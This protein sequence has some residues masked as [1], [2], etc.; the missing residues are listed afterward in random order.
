[1]E[2]S[3]LKNKLMS[4]LA[5]AKAQNLVDL[6]VIPYLDLINS[7]PFFATSSSCYGRLVIMDLPSKK[8]NE[9][10][11]LRKWH[12]KISLDEFLD[13]LYNTHGKRIWFKVD[14]LI[15]H[16]SVD[17]V[18]H[19]SRLLDVKTRAGIKRGGIF[20]IRPNRVQIEVEGTQ[21]MEVPIKFDNRVL[22]TDDYAE[23][24]VNEANRKMEENIKQ[25]ERFEKEFRNEFREELSQF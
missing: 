2:W 11:F 1:M 13:G 19:A 6:E 3:Q 21:K 7:L 17:N 18:E 15:L 24:L 20:S 14:P 5:E 4:G 25:W 23:I 22:I 12:R 10:Q 8:K 9:S 16:V